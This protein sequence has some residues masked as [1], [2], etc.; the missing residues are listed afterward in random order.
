VELITDS[1]TCANARRPDQRRQPRSTHTVSKWTSDL[2]V[3]TREL[4]SGVICPPHVLS[5]GQLA[6]ACAKGAVA[7]GA[8]ICS[9][10]SSR[11]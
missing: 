2:S 3:V 4:M 8:H 7:L 10:M 9:P 1:L 11:L 6:S 5:A